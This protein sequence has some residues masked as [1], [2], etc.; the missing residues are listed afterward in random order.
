[1]KVL[2]LATIISSLA[3]SLNAQ[4]IDLCIWQTQRD[5]MIKSFTPAG[6]T[7]VTQ[8]LKDLQVV[9][10]AAVQPIYNQIKK[11]NQALITQLETTDN[12]TFVQ[13]WT[14]LGYGNLNCGTGQLAD[15][16]QVY[17]TGTNL[18]YKFKPANQP[19]VFTLSQSVVNKINSVYPILYAIVQ[20]K[21]ADLIAQ[22]VKSETPESLNA[23]GKFMGA[24]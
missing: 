20:Q 15:L 23:F 1:M 13:F 17:S 4:F 2:L 19:A 14:M 18:Y 12:P 21:D 22:L 7:I 3:L 5:Q 6:Q 24:I 10:G 16:C 11:D 9:L 8:L